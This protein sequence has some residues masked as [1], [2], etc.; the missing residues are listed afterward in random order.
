MSVIGDH[1][2][3]FSTRANVLDIGP[4]ATYIR[5]IYLAFQIIPSHIGLP[6]LVITFL[7]SKGAKRHPTLINVCI[8]WILSGIFSVMLLYA[9]QETGPEPNGVLC[10]AQTSLLYGVIPMWSV[11]ILMLVYYVWTSYGSRRYNPN[12]LTTYAIIAAPYITLVVWSGAAAVLANL[13]PGKVNRSRRFFYCSIHSS[14]LSNAMST[15]TAVV[16]IAITTIEIRIATMLYRNWRGLKRAG[17]ASGVSVQ[18]VL[19]ILVF[20]TYIFLSMIFSLSTMWEPHSV[21]PDMFGA[22][23]GF[24]VMLIFG[25]Q[26]DI[27]RTWFFWRSEK[28]QRVI[29]LSREPS[30]MSRKF[31]LDEKTDP[32]DDDISYIGKPSPVH[33]KTPSSHSPV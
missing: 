2:A 26:P 6:L 14:P 29:N 3:G 5:N 8:S 20:G 25:S 12:A 9:D 16:C 22:T 11:A 21:V 15:F 33:F 10:R 7:F 13:H 24:A 4:N 17:E 28:P 32:D 1:P 31:D 23:I 30:F 27:W 19:R 18:F